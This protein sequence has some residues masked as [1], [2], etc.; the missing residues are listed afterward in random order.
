M[1]HSDVNLTMSTYTN[2]MLR[3][4]ASDLDKLPS[5]SQPEVLRATATAS[6]EV[7]VAPMV[8]LETVQ[9][10]SS[11]ELSVHVNDLNESL[12][13]ETKNPRKLS[14]CEGLCDVVITPEKGPSLGLEPRTYALRKRRST[15]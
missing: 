8:A 3:D 12:V 11:Q 1:R 10:K 6:T 9:R 14:S 4:V 5:L 13:T 7:L 15:D 2:L